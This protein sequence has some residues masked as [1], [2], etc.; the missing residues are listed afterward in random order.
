MQYET[1]GPYDLR[2]SVGTKTPVTNTRIITQYNERQA[3][4]I[5]LKTP[6]QII[7]PKLPPMAMFPGEIVALTNNT[8]ICHGCDQEVANG[9]RRCTSE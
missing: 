7:I 8:W 9:K 1:V 3:E 5:N 2:F 6:P 4:V